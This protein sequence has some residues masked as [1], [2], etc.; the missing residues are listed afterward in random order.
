MKNNLYALIVGIDDYAAPV[1]KLSGC[2]P[3]AKSV[4]QYLLENESKNF[5]LKIQKRFNAEATRAN[6]TSDFLKHLAMATENDVVLFFY[7]GHGA[8]EHADPVIW[9][10]EPNRKL[11]GLVLYDSVP[12]S[13]E[14]CK[15]LVDKELRY[16]LSYVATQNEK[17]EKKKK[18][19]HI[20]VI[21]DCCHSGE[22]TRGGGF[23]DGLVKRNFDGGDRPLTQRAYED[24]L[25]S[26][27]KNI[28]PKKLA[29]MPI[30]DLFP[31]VPHVAMAACESSELASERGGHGVFTSNLI[32]IL[33]RSDG[34]VTYRDL[35]NRIANYLKNQF[36][37]TPVIYASTDKNDLFKGFL[38]KKG[39]SKPMY[40]NVQ[41]NK[42]EG[43][44]MDMG[45]IHGISNQAKGVKIMSFD[46][47]ISVDATIGKIS[48]N[49]TALTI[50]NAAKLDKE[51]QYKGI[52]EGFLSAPIAVFIDDLDSNKVMAKALIDKIQSQ[53]KNL[54]ISAKED[55]ADYAVRIFG[56]KYVITNRVDTDPKVKYKPLVMPTSDMEA[57]FR[58]L[59]HISQ[60]EYV[61][62][63]ENS[64]SNKM[65]LGKVV[66][67]F[68]EEGKTTP[69]PIQNGKGKEFV[70]IPFSGK[71]GSGNPTGQIT[72]TVTSNHDKPIYV[73]L[74]YMSPTFGIMTDMLAANVQFLNNKGDK[75]LIWDG[76]AVGL[77]Y[78]PVL[79]M[80]NIPSADT[81]F[82]LIVSREPFDVTAFALKDLTSAEGLVM[83]AKGDPFRSLKRISTNTE[84]AD[85][86]MTRSILMR[87]PNSSYDKDY[88]NK[89]AKYNDWLNTEGGIFLK[90]LYGA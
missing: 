51:A 71:D 24:F 68:F 61:K 44:I 8:Q 83:A 72:M 18:S 59:D 39:D 82:K 1:G 34:Q 76:D 54:N 65:D 73:S 70:D 49:S 88:K 80:F 31:L 62:R 60:F 41:F 57:C 42:T 52:I 26:K 85:A 25:F 5:E 30:N 33:K 67:E 2:V 27:D 15:L 20:V 79:G 6:I 89:P 74:L 50:A 11:Q 29:T 69:T 46:N 17:G 36:P 37:Q 14:N 35:Q 12:R 56:G 48:N 23:G 84:E 13:F 87:N 78:D 9:P 53:G 7:A 21:T 75:A 4:E 3:D 45:A 38:G 77:V 28:T 16:L 86:W 64:G 63:L 66:L 10:S 22:N 55:I 43:W 81:V 40:A 58:D 32:N 47:K 19:P 90:K